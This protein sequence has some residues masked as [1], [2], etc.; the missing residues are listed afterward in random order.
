MVGIYRKHITLYELNHIKSL[1]PLRVK[2]GIK[3]LVA[4]RAKHS[5]RNIL[6]S[7]QVV[8]KECQIKVSKDLLVLS[9]RCRAGF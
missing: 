4:R 6:F 1:K 2:F 5:P 3:A 8:G 9:D 7:P